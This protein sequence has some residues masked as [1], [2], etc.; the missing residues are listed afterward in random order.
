MKGI[1]DRASHLFL[2]EPASQLSI[3]HLRACFMT[4]HSNTS[5]LMYDGDLG[6]RGGI[7][8]TAREMPKAKHAYSVTCFVRG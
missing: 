2:Q 1:R 4:K 8:T 5:R 3:L 6:S 7:R